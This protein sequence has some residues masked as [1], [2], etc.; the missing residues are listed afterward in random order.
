MKR[1]IALMAIFMATTGYAAIYVHQSDNGS[2]EYSD[3]PS[4]NAKEV[5]VAPLNTVAPVVNVTPP[6]ADDSAVATTPGEV[7]AGLPGATTVSTGATYQAFSITTPK[8]GDTIQNQSVIPVSM[9][10]EPTMTA[11]DK[12]Q[13]YLDGKAVGTPTSTIYQELSN[14]ERG[15]HSLYAEIINS[16][17]QGIKKSNSITIHVHRNSLITSPATPR[18]A[19]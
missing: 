10:I 18:P 9:N 4:A 5:Q 17:M 19:N 13:L 7:V 6:K 1:L 8:D 11:G 14:V 3:T 16:N 15:T 2:I 12:I